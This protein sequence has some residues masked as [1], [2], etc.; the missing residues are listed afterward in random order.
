MDTFSKKKRSEIMSNVKDRDSTIEVKVRKALH[1][2]GYRYRKN[3]TSMFGK[4]DLVFAKSRVVV[5]IDSCFWHGCRWHC[6]MPE[7]NKSFWIK[8]IN[9]NK[10]R[11][12]EVN[13][14]YRD[15]GW[16]VVRIWEHQINKDFDT[17]IKKITE[18]L[19][20]K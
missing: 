17:V 2:A 3:V 16:T 7:S 20:K 10:A 5:F 19:L 4:P 9:R 15:C 12:K 11:D 14:Y 1:Q 8:K 6:K 18:K 13:K